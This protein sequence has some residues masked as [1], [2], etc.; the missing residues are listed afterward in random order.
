MISQPISDVTTFTCQ[1]FISK[2]AFNDIKTL[3]NEL[4]GAMSSNAL[5]PFGAH[6]DSTELNT[7]S[8]I[9]PLLKAIILA[10]LYPRVSHVMLPR[11]ALKFDQ[12]AAGSVQRENTAKEYKVLDM[13]GERVWIHPASM[14]FNES[15][16]KSG[17][18]VSFMRVA[19]SKVFLRDV[20]EVS[21]PAT[22][23][24]LPLKAYHRFRF[25]LCFCLVE[26]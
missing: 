11:G 10:A 3:R 8:T 16:W 20:T 23:A 14:M 24:S 13:K 25:T 15:A 6:S 1:N 18:V 9:V 5:V 21:E 19:T 26:I 2:S 22:A 12:T 17:F 4:F 7:N